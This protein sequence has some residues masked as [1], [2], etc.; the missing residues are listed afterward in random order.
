MAFQRNWR[1]FAAATV[2]GSVWLPAAAGAQGAGAEPTEEIIVTS[3]I[4]ATPR[5][6]LATAVSVIDGPDIELRGYDNLA[7]VLRTQPGIG[8]TNSGG[9][10]KSTTLRIRGEDGFRTLLMIDGVK[11][12]DPSTPQVGPSFDSLL[13]TNDLERVEVLR[14]PQGFIYGADSGGVV[15]VLTAR[16][17]GPIGGRVGVEYGAH[18]TRK[19]DAGLSGRGDRGD[20]FVSVTDFETDGFNSRTADT[21]LRDDDGAD[22]TTL[23]AKLGWNAAESLRLQLVARDVDASAL[24]DECFHPVTFATV[25]DCR[26]TTEQTTYKASADLESGMLTH[27]VGYSRVDIARDNFAAGSSYFAT[28]GAIGRFEYTGALRRSDQLALVYGAD[29][30]SEEMFDGTAVLDRDQA[31]YYV[32]YQGAFDDRL[33]LSLGARYDDNDDFGSHT[34]SRLSAAYLQDLGVSGVLKYRASTG[35]GFRAPSLFEIAYNGGPFSFPPAA[36]LEL[37]EESSQG[38][39]LGVDYDAMSGLHLEAT[40]FDQEIEDQIFFDIVGFSGY[41][42]SLGT[43]KS[44]GVELGLTAPVGERW[45]ILANWTHNDTVDTGNVP[46]VRCPENIANLGL[47]YTSPDDALR[48][49]VNYRV[50]HDAI[51]IGGTPLDDY[52]VLDLSLAYSVSD[53]VEL[54]ARVQN[55]A[56]ETYQEIV[57]YNT[58]GRSAYAGVRLRFR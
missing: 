31:G 54:Y 20:Y 53:A 6:Q 5:R 32:E 16:G 48:L 36:G 8:V 28:E 44:K 46:R 29:L 35:T 13:T 45:E 4:V 56:D 26:V 39:D 55:A 27:S 14:G 9:P 7:D 24:F 42:Q 15:N 34:S 38:Y 25:H 43:S 50:S 52:A 33:F 11:A 37:R 47:G 40:Y 30:Q 22:N 49:I 51:D 57:G 10:G 58:A 3:S 21:V 19:L 12:L 1:T 18:D 23:H 41:L 17:D 2:A